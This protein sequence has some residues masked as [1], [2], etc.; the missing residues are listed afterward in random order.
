MR[1]SNRK[2]LTTA[3][4]GL[5]LLL[6]AGCLRIPDRDQ[7][8][9]SGIEPA[10]WAERADRRLY[11]GAPPVIPHDRLGASCVSCHVTLR[12]AAVG[13]GV[14]PTSPH[15]ATAGLSDAS[16]CV[17]CHVYQ[18]TTGTFV[19]NDF[20][21]VRVESPSGTRLYAGAP[22]VMPHRLHMREDCMAC[23]TGPGARPE[24]VTTHPERTRCRQCHVEAT[25]SDE[26]ASAMGPS[27]NPE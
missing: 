8:A 21:P 5:S 19:A 23:H 26:F 22:P 12:P 2:G 24:I 25:T 15:A 7:S 18:L 3:A 1:G 11:D 16:R 20:V 27:A 17:Q 9:A 6:L 14:P 4:V 13:I 10:S